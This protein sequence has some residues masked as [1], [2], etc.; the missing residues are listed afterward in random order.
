MFTELSNVIAET[1]LSIMYYTMI[2]ITVSDCMNIEVLGNMLDG[3]S[4]YLFKDITTK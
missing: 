2:I 4:P 3:K 1:N